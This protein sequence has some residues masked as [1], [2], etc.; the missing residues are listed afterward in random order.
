[1][2]SVPTQSPPIEQVLDLSAFTASRIRKRVPIVRIIIGAL[3]VVFIL[4]VAVFVVTNPRLQWDVFLKYLVAPEVMSGLAITVVLAFVAQ[5]LGTILGV[6]FATF[7]LSIFKPLQWLATV[8]VTLFRTP[9]A[10]V[11]LVFWFNIAYL[12]PKIEIRIPFGPLL[13][14][15]DTNS[16]VTPMVAAVLGL[17]LIQ[18][19]YM[20]EIVRAG[21]MSVD[22]GQRDAAKAAGYTPW[23]S[24][25]RIVFPQSIRVIIPPTGGQ[26]I[27]VVHGTAL[28]SVIAVGDLLFSV[29]RVYNRTFEVI[30]LLLVATFW[31]LVIVL[32]LSYF[33]QWAE[34]K[35]GRGHTREILRIKR[36]TPRATETSA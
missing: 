4:Q 20:T 17:S 31:Y 6:V 16:V 30:P 10:L 3:L 34:R 32:A 23:Q 14:E 15:W 19:A 27:N 12:I 8:Y 5:L 24:F 13:A 7:R 35:Y 26:F 28:V 22:V 1:M 18:G 11:Q 2:P 29:Q 36:P 21:I 33:Q 9:P 25:S